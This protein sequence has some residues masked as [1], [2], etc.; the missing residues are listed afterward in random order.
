MFYRATLHAL[1]MQAFK[2]RFFEILFVHLSVT[3]IG[4]LC[5]KAKAPVADVPIA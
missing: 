2:D 4:I 1:L 5:N 3:R